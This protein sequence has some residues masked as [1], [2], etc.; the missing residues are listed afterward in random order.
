MK[1]SLIEMS[2]RFARTEAER[3]ARCGDKLTA[4][5]Q[6]IMRAYKSI[7][8]GGRVINLKKTLE[9]GGFDEFQRPKLALCSAACTRV[10]LRGWAGSTE[11]RWNHRNY[12]RTSIRVI[13]FGHGH[14]GSAITEA[15][16]TMPYIPPYIRRPRMTKYFVLWEA[17]WFN[18]PK[19]DPYLL[20][21]IDE[22][23]FRIIAAWD[24]TPLEAAVLR[25]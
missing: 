24:I 17:T 16:A 19:G 21:K 15:W 4:Q 9:A 25:R 12:D 1:T 20:E 11:F 10:N 5:D 18:L 8:H 6:K 22:N 3:Y 13:G 2:P 23:L 14:E 7:A